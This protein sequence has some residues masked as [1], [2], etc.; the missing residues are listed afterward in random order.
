VEEYFRDP[1]NGYDDLIS[2][3]DSIIMYL[4]QLPESELA[5]NCSHWVSVDPSKITWAEIV[6]EN[7]VLDPKK[8]DETD[9]QFRERYVAAY[10]EQIAPRETEDEAAYQ[11]RIKPMFDRIKQRKIN[12]ES[13]R[14]KNG[15]I[16]LK[17][18]TE[19]R[20]LTSRVFTYHAAAKALD[21]RLAIEAYDRLEAIITAEKPNQ[22]PGIPD[23]VKA[24]GLLLALGLMVL[25]VLAGIKM[26]IG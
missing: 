23:W 10:N 8:S 11:A 13:A 7:L 6:Q 9:E 24:I 2:Y 3:D 4:Y 5:E 20:I 14:L 21:V 22:K 25:M 17:R 15:I 19:R 1:K 12:E 18:E 16:R 26:L